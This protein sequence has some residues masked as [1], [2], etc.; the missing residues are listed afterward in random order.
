[1]TIKTAQ[2]HI[3]QPI[4][5][6]SA[7]SERREKETTTEAY[8]NP[9]IQRCSPGVNWLAVNRQ[10]KLGASIDVESEFDGDHTADSTPST[11]G[12]RKFRR[13]E[14]LK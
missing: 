2:N 5:S 12:N 10:K 6:T 14:K 1:M 11:C 3:T 4:N 7:S 8:E 9:G 13:G